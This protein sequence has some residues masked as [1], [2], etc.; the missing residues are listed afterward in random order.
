MATFLNNDIYNSW[1]R[2]LREATMAPRYADLYTAEFGPLV[3]N[4]LLD[5]LLPNLLFVKVMS[6]L[7]EALEFYIDNTSSLSGVNNKKL[8]D[9][10][11]VLDNMGLISDVTALHDLRKLRNDIAHE[12]IVQIDWLKLENAINTVE[13]QLQQLG[14]VGDR[15]LY[16]TF[17]GRNV[18]L[19]SSHPE[20]FKTFHY[21]VGLKED[22][23]VVVFLAWRNHHEQ[24]H[25]WGKVT[26]DY[27]NMNEFHSQID[28]EEVQE[29]LNRTYINQD[30][31]SI[32][33][34]IQKQQA[35]PMIIA[36]IIQYHHPDKGKTL[37]NIL[38]SDDFKDVDWQLSDKV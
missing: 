22:K 26:A 6:V 24:Y 27:D 5:F 23:K 32:L 20:A 4:P 19:P 12:T 15:P 9:R 31:D 33:S 35:L 13:K 36:A 38:L 18:E 25:N 29:F 2:L 3:P 1:L 37:E 30:M 16:E 7:D 34:N 14:F 21:Y 11:N 10:I 28:E 17:S 8:F